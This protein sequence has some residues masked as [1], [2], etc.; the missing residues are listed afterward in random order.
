MILSVYFFILQLFFLIP[1]SQSIKI[2]PTAPSS[3]IKRVIHKNVATEVESTNNFVSSGAVNNQ[4]N[5]LTCW[6]DRIG[7]EIQRHFQNYWNSLGSALENLFSRQKPINICYPHSD[8]SIPG[9]ITAVNA[10]SDSRTDYDKLNEKT[11]QRIFDMIEEKEGKWD[12]IRVEDGFEV[13]RL[14]SN[15][16]N[17]ACVKCGGVINSSPQKVRALLE[18][19]TR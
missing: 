19:S 1:L 4:N 10:T 8:D 16:S 3:T 6:F 13:H 18:N 7:I 12:L 15:Q 14:Y 2:F 5:K 11:L 17:I 9:N